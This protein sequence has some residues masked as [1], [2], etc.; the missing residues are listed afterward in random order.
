MEYP[1]SAESVR[2]LK[3]YGK[4]EFGNDLGTRTCSL[5]SYREMN[6]YF[7][8][9]HTTVAYMTG[10]SPAQSSYYDLYHAIRREVGDI[11]NGH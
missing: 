4:V 11:E 6:D 3:T 7:R 10:S 2:I 5:S 9:Y 1:D 8:Y